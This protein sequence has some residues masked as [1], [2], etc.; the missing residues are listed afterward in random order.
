MKRSC[1]PHRVGVK[2]AS[3]NVCESPKALGAC[4]TLCNRSH[5]YCCSSLFLW[6]PYLSSWL[7]IHLSFLP[8]NFG[9]LLCSPDSMVMRQWNPGSCLRGSGDWK[10][11]TPVW[12]FVLN[13]LHHGLSLCLG[14]SSFDFCLEDRNSLGNGVA[15]FPMSSGF[16]SN[17]T[18]SKGLSKIAFP[19]HQY[20]LFPSLL[21][22]SSEH[23]LGSIR[24][25]IYWGL[26]PQ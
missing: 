1:P 15:S 10:A 18:L 12:I 7:E 8:Q 4:V 25:L 14:P 6:E 3:F 9:G 26:C 20:F 22:S 5:P 13:R 2:V 24:C 16:C 17:V 21:Y 11:A 19:S 23:T